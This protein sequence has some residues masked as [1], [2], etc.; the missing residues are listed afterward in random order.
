MGVKESKIEMV[1][2]SQDSQSTEEE[3]AA[4]CESRRDEA[5]AIGGRS[6]LIR[7]GHGGTDRE[8]RCGV[9]KKQGQIGKAEKKGTKR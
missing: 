3:M 6:A 1:L 5:R 7:R 8:K 9:V 2:P 4:K